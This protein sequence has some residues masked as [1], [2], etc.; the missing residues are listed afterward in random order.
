[1]NFKENLENLQKLPESQKKIILFAIVGVLAV[2]M[3]IF[4]VRGVIKTASSI[5]K[6]MGKI[7]LPAIDVSDMPKVPD[8]NLLSGVIPENVEL[9]PYQSRQ[10]FSFDYPGNFTVSENY[11]SSEVI[12]KNEKG[13][14][15]L[16]IV[17]YDS[18]GLSL[19]EDVIKSV[20]Q[21]KKNSAG[22]AAPVSV[23]YGGATM[24]QLQ[25]YLILAKAG[26]VLEN[27]DASFKITNGEEIISFEYS[28]QGYILKPDSAELLFEGENSDE[29]QKEMIAKAFEYEQIQDMVF[30]L[31]F[32][33]Q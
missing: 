6:E 23:S 32:D 9:K 29:A 8:L 4:W 15:I 21:I 17:S 24:G 25:G 3:G 1:M 2:I 11:E 7:E 14:N 18:T 31:K 22:S 28:Y 26:D 19:E 13:D 33:N 30:S 20:A 27:T 12:V 16:N 5:G 10:G